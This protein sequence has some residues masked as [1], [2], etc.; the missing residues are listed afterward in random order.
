MHLTRTIWPFFKKFLFQ[1]LYLVLKKILLKFHWNL[2]FLSGSKSTRKISYLG[3]IRRH[4]GL[5]YR[6]KSI[7]LIF[8]S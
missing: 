4:L 5:T 2:P 6:E 7:G 8:S 3:T 1:A